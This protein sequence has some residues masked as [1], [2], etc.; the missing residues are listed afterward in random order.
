M[1]DQG[2]VN[3]GDLLGTEGEEENDETIEGFRETGEEPTDS[4]LPP[5]EDQVSSGDITEEKPS[6]EE[7]FGKEEDEEPSTAKTASLVTTALRKDIDARIQLARR[8]MNEDFAANKRYVALA[9]T[10]MERGRMYLGKILGV[11]GVRQN[12]YPDGYNPKSSVIEAAADTNNADLQ[13][14]HMEKG[15]SVAFVKQL[16]LEFSLAINAVEVF[17]LHF[18]ANSNGSLFVNEALVSMHDVTNWLGMELGA[19]RDANLKQ[20]SDE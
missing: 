19:I 14:V 6:V 7:A 4:Q 15:N 9:I 2:N 1:D 8:Y 20:S 5:T 11:Y 10:A 12:P 13:S 16:K 17:R 3:L 18:P